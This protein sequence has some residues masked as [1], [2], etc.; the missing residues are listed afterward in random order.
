ML[1]ISFCN[2]TGLQLGGGGL[3]TYLGKGISVVDS[4][5]DQNIATSDC[6]GGVEFEDMSSVILDTVCFTG[7]SAPSGGAGCSWDKSKTI[8]FS[9]VTSYGNYAQG[10]NK[11]CKDFYVDGSCKTLTSGNCMF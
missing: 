7:N 5:F 11:A 6:G 8:T 10:G 2:L 3:Y 9:S 4:K 1:K